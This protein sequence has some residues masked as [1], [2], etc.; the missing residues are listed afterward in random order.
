MSIFQIAF[1]NAQALSRD[2]VQYNSTLLWSM[3]MENLRV[4]KGLGLVSQYESLAACV[5]QVEDS[6]KRLRDVI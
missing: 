4:S 1:S 5:V 2:A 3:A 6:R